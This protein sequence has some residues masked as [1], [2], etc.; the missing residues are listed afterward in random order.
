MG[1]SSAASFGPFGHEGWQWNLFAVVRPPLR[2]HGYAE[3]RE[4]AQAAFRVARERA[5]SDK[6]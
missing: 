4:Q 2:N 1:R 5:R 3:T 6:Q